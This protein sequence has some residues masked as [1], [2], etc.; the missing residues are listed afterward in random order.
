M[1]APLAEP[2][3]EHG[4][5]GRVPVLTALR[6]REYR[7]F[8]IGAAFSNIGIWALMTGHLWL[9]HT[10]T[11]SPFM[12]GLLTFS[13]A[14]PILLLSMW[15]GVVADRVN[16]LKLVT[17][18]RATF[19]LLAFLTAPLVYFDVIRPSHL[20]AL[21]LTYG[22]LVSFDIPCRQAI[23]PNLVRREHLLNAIVL[24]SFLMGGAGIIGPAF[25]GPIVSSVGL[26]GLFAFVGT[27]YAGTV[28]MLMMMRPMPNRPNPEQG[29]LWDDLLRGLG[30]IRA[31]WAILSLILMGVVT[32]IFGSAF[33]TLLPIFAAEILEGDVQSYGNLL[34]SLGV[35]GMLGMV[36]LAAF[37]N[38][39]NSVVLQLVAGVGFGLGLAVFCQISFFPLSLAVLALVGGSGVAF[40]TINNTLVQTLVDDEFRGRVMSIHQLGWGASAIGGLVMG[41][42]AEVLGAPLTLALG[43][44]VT[45]IATAT[46]TLSAARS[47][48]AGPEALA[49]RASD[50]AQPAGGP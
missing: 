29:K 48:A 12:L 8:W 46:L 44:I 45:A 47:M 36:V 1:V 43:G 28:V 24:Y 2:G 13:G 31:R 6:Y 50:G 21:S 15:G 19:S 16:R 35:G 37:G 27:A 4:A 17:Y 3:Q 10:L 41:G 5:S 14:G 11:S 34:L 9:M 38:L 32:G 25:F 22:V 18:S 42:L 26:A 49:G 39:K 20:I 33:G 7:L 23:V 40:G 30:Y